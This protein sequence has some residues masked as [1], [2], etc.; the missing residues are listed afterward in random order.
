MLLFFLLLANVGSYTPI[1]Q[2]DNRTFGYNFNIEGG[3]SEYDTYI[4]N[5]FNINENYESFYVFKLNGCD[6]IECEDCKKRNENLVMADKVW[7]K[8]FG[9]KC[10]GTSSYYNQKKI[11]IEAFGIN[12]MKKIEESIKR[13]CKLYDVTYNYNTV[14]V[15]NITK[16]QNYDLSYRDPRCN[17]SICFE[18]N[19]NC[20]LGNLTRICCECNCEYNHVQPIIYEEDSVITIVFLSISIVVLLITSIYYY[21]EARIIRKRINENINSMINLTR[22]SI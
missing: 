5:N 7:Y 21:Y 22:Q 10:D 20:S 12:N 9:A 18:Q 1:N 11:K 19:C 14:T 16:T 17:T 13:C 2:F 8:Q 3:K 6:F 15:N 4:K